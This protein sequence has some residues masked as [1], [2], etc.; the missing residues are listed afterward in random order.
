MKE[1]EHHETPDIPG[2]QAPAGE[3]IS[4][5]TYPI[6]PVIEPIEPPLDPQPIEDLRQ[7]VPHV[8]LP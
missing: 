6:L 3:P 7:I 1:V 5:I 2:G 8:Q 4:G